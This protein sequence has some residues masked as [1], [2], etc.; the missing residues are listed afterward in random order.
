VHNVKWEKRVEGASNVSRHSCLISDCARNWWGTSTKVVGQFSDGEHLPRV[1]GEFSEEFGFVQC[2]SGHVGNDEPSCNTFPADGAHGVSIQRVR[3]VP[4]T[5]QAQKW[6][7]KPI[8]ITSR[9][10]ANDKTIF[11][12]HPCIVA[13]NVRSTHFVKAIG[14]PGRLEPNQHHTGVSHGTTIGVPLCFSSSSR[15]QLARRKMATET[16]ITMST[17]VA[18][19]PASYGSLHPP[20]HLTWQE[21]G[22]YM[23]ISCLKS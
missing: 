1:V 21:L 8:D 9:H 22:P 15:T 11:P 13:T 5:E 17:V 6:R 4:T 2:R 10:P 19:L 3:I 18:S 14:C 23:D 12:D 20:R 16:N 7:G